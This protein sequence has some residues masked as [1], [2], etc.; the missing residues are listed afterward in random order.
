[1]RYA[2]FSLV[3]SVLGAGSVSAQRFVEIGAGWTHLASSHALSEKIGNGA[4]VRASIGVPLT[5]RVSGRLDLAGTFFHRKSEYFPPCPAPGCSHP[6]YTS[7]ANAVL[8]LTANDLLNIDQRGVF[9]L[10]GGP[11]VYLADGRAS[12]LHLGGD[13][14]VGVSI[15]FGGMHALVEAKVSRLFGSTTGPPW[16]VP[17][18]LGLRF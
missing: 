6:F 16:M 12:E 4:N 8:G 5:P 13:A 11:G 3:V 17:V 2:V 7:D 15:P 9:Y 1:M 10:I 14:G 18:S